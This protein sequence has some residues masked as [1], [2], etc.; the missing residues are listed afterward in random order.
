MMMNFIAIRLD[1]FDDDYYADADADSSS[2]RRR[3]ECHVL[4][5]LFTQKTLIIKF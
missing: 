2:M 5:P 1:G 4:L 3:H